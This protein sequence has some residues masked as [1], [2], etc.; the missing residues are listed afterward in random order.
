M[1]DVV[2]F[3]SAK[4]PESDLEL[5]ERLTKAVQEMI[6]DCPAR[7]AHTAL[8]NVL[9]SIDLS[10]VEGDPIKYFEWRW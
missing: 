6:R 7:I 8:I 5:E 2:E 3:S 9:V 4:R 10:C 1:G